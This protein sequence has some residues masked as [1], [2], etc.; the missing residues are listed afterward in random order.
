MIE[1]KWKVLIVVSIGVF[2]G[3]LNGSIVNIAN[4]T[5]AEVFSISMTEVQWVV[6]V[7]MLVVTATM[8]FFGKLGDKIGS[9]RL[10]VVGFAVF[11]LGSLVC[12]LSQS[13]PMLIGARI[14]QAIGGS[15]LMATGLGLVSN[16]FPQEE[17][18]KAIGMVGAVVGVGNLSGASI[19]GL[20]L[21]SFSWQSIFYLNVPVGILGALLGIFFLTPQQK[22]NEIKGF[23][24]PGI[25]LFASATTVALLAINNQGG[26]GVFLGLGA[27]ILLILLILWEKRSKEPFLDMP[28]FTIRD[29]T[30]GNIIG[31]F[32]YFPQMS[33]AFLLPFY[34]EEVKALSTASSGLVMTVHPLVMVLIAPLAGSLSDRFGSRPIL[35]V[36]FALMTLS[37]GA[38]GFLTAA[39]PLWLLVLCLAVFGLGVGSFGSPNNSTVLA[40]V[41]PQKQGYG[42]SFLATMRN[43][44]FGA[45]TA[46][47]S[48]FFAARFAAVT[49]T[50]TAYAAALHDSYWAAAAL[51][52]IGLLLTLFFQKNSKRVQG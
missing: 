43:L 40:G 21:Q 20:L 18:G 38:L 3:T 16:A 26:H 47:F 32:C 12:G 19:G 34:L 29:F 27:A 17:K 11:S 49:P 24:L 1:Q 2:M 35:M 23:D 48:A 36:S 31:V 28:L 14:F 51:C 4:P 33:V 46:F 8:L 41:S 7:Y 25:L 5:I 10:Y 42:G 52:F 44:S 37:L 6:T 13:F 39:T 15:I 9:H 50:D 45:G 30:M 22:N